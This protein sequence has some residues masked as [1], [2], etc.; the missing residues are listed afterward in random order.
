MN[1][2]TATIISSLIDSD[3]H[4]WSVIQLQSEEKMSRLMEKLKKCQ[5]TKDFYQAHQICRTIFVRLRST[6]KD[7]EILDFLFDSARYFL[8]NEQNNSGYDLCKSYVEILNK[9]K[10]NELT[11]NL[12]EQIL[13]LFQLLKFS[14]DDRTEFACNVLRWSTTI[15]LTQ[16]QP[17]DELPIGRNENHS[18]FSSSILSTLTEPSSSSTTTTNVEKRIYHK[19]GHPKLH[20]AFA[21]I[22]W[23]KERNYHDSR[24][25][26]LRSFD[27]RSFATMLI[28]AHQAL[29][30]PSEID[31]FIGQTVLQ[32]LLLRNFHTAYLVFVTYVEQHPKIRQSPPGPFN[33]VY[34]MLNFLWFLLL[35]LKKILVKRTSNA[36]G[37]EKNIV[38]L[39][40]FNVEISSIFSFCFRL[41]VTSS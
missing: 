23:E 15:P 36:A 41:V 13:K 32:Y 16:N 40:L 39:R 10:I 34:P 11:S 26:Y 3:R 33:Q 17:E 6:S 31:L 19:T 9:S 8:E 5:E 29:G 25:H 28:E 24:Y 20:E 22:L 4:R 18:S 37:G 12:V 38:F 30:Y 21:H 35:C 1:H 14:H 2:R 27:G 7:E